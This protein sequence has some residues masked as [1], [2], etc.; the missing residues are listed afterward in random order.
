MLAET[1]CSDSIESELERSASAKPGLNRTADKHVAKRA[2]KY[3]LER[4]G[5]G[6]AFRNVVKDY[7]GSGLS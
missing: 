1:E 3:G 5:T 7:T 6:V 4:G 2:R